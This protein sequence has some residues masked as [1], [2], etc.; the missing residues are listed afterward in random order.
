MGIVV[1]GS[2]CICLLDFLDW[3]ERAQMFFSSS[4]RSTQKSDTRMQPPSDPTMVNL[5][6]AE[7]EKLRAA[8][9]LSYVN[10]VACPE[11]R[12]YLLSFG[13]SAM[14]RLAAELAEQERHFQLEYDNA[15]ITARPKEFPLTAEASIRAHNTYASRG[16]LFRHTKASQELADVQAKIKKLKEDNAKLRKM[17]GLPK[18]FDFAPPLALPP[19][20]AVPPGAQCLVE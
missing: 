4:F 17:Y 2:H 16:L 5:L 3:N 6:L 10:R 11:H 19:Q 1:M 13:H 14:T 15:V 9:M 20:N 7:Y 8:E 12:L 18:G